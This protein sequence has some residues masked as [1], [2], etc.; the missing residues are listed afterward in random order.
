MQQLSLFA[1]PHSFVDFVN[2]VSVSLLAPTFVKGVALMAVVGCVAFAMKRSSPALRYRAWF[3][4]VAALALLPLATVILPSWSAGILPAGL[5]PEPHVVSTYT[6]IAES[7]TIVSVPT[8]PARP[9]RLLVIDPEETSSDRVFVVQA[10]SAESVSAADVAPETS[11]ETATRSVVANAFATLTAA[12]DSVDWRSMRV[13]GWIGFVW[14]IGMIV[15]LTRLAL[16]HFSVARMIKR[17]TRNDD[18]DWQLLLEEV[19]LHLGVTE[20]VKLRWSEH[21]V[22]P[23]NAGLLQ[24]VVLI[25]ESGADWSPERRRSVLLHELA[26]VKRRDCLTHFVTQIVRAVHWMNPFIWHAASEMISDREKAADDLVLAAGT[27]PSIYARVL[28]ETAQAYNS[29]NWSAP[30]SLAMARKSQLEN[31]MLAILDPAKRFDASSPAN[32]ILS[33]LV[34]V[35]VALPLAA[36]SP[37]VAQES[38]QQ[39][40]RQAKVGKAEVS[41]APRIVTVPEVHVSVP[42]VAVSVPGLSFD[43]VGEYVVAPFDF[44]LD[45][46][47]MA[48]PDFDFDVDLSGFEYELAATDFDFPEFEMAMD[49]PKAFA[50]SVGGGFKRDGK[51]LVV[52]DSLTIDQIIR[53]R[54]YGVDGDFVR[55]IKALGYDTPMYDDLVAIARYGAGPDFIRSMRAAGFSGLSLSEYAQAARYDMNPEFASAMRDA[56][57]G[58]LSLADLTLLSRYDASPE[59][60]RGLRSAGLTNLS[61]KDVATLARYDANVEMINSLKS[62]G[63]NDLSVED[64]VKASRYDV[65]VEYISAM[66]KAGYTNLSLDEVASLARYGIRADLVDALSKAGYNNLSVDEL[67]SVGRYDVTPE[68]IQG[69]GQAGYSGLSIG[70]IVSFSRYGVDA[71]YIT[72]LKNVGMTGLTSEQLAQMRRYDVDADFIESIKKAGIENPTVEQLI[73]MQRN[74]VDADFI[75]SLKAN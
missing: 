25:P 40:T 29:A 27:K 32:R 37:V 33:S 74:G 24:S 51:A 49:A 53:L 47:D 70:E 26:H 58:E 16:A 5:F 15:G 45:E 13:A 59:M 8:E 39:T 61:A 3:T 64:I 60:I 2:N 36:F 30:A 23:L 67:R 44:D 10:P 42:P 55:D 48:I 12:F 50:V 41:V 52:G 19:S 56:G 72:S 28:L 65:D 17:S 54:R 6:R 7:P 11:T 9:D 22:V 21:S 14:M 69:L 57:L 20:R 31:R 68:V 35:A 46:F 75:K 38:S 18:D 66:R 71:D 62:L 63:Y 1:D 34:I 73:K 4:G 43:S